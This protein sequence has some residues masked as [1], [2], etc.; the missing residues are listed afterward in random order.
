[1]VGRWVGIVLEAD[2][3][4]RLDLPRGVPVTIASMVRYTLT[5]IAFFLALAAVGVDVSQIAIIG[6][7]LSVGIGFGLQTIV[8]NFISGL[9]LAFERPL[10]VG[11]TIQLGELEGEV[12]SIGIRA[13]II[14]TFQGADVI[15]PNGQLIS[16]EVINWTR[17]DRTRRLEVPVG[18]AYGTD[19]G[20]V[21]GLLAGVAAGHPRV[22]PHPEPLCLFQG[23][24]ES[25]LEFLLRFWTEAED[26]PV[27]RSEVRVAVHDALKAAG[28]EIPF[29]QRDV[30]V[31]TLPARATTGT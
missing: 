23:F 27:V 6:G 25:S 31:R 8:H 15:V 22:R 30:H 14:R 2:V 21:I 9:I 20:T 7:A 17:S 19:P 16:T 11:D 29:P 1:M 3:L 18:V 28:I 12:R 5:A 4:D 24:G 13:S 10:A 26:F